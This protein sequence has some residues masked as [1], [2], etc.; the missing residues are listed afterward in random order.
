MKIIVDEKEWVHNH[1]WK[2]IL[3]AQTTRTYLS[4]MWFEEY[5]PDWTTWEN[6]DPNELYFFIWQ[7]EWRE[8]NSAGSIIPPKI[9]EKSLNRLRTYPNVIFLC[10]W[11]E[12]SYVQGV[13]YDELNEIISSLDIP[14]NRCHVVLS[15]LAYNQFESDNFIAHNI[16]YWTIHILH[17]AYSDSNAF[18]YQAHSE[19]RNKKALCLNR[20][21]REHRRY[22]LA[23][24]YANGYDTDTY[25]SNLSNHDTAIE[26]PRWAN[27]DQFL[28]DIFYNRCGPVHLD[29]TSEVAISNIIDINQDL[30]HDSY[31]HLVNETSFNNSVSNEQLYTKLLFITEKTL[32]PI[33]YKQLFIVVGNPG[34]LRHLHRLGVQTFPELFDE[35]Y[36][37]EHDPNKRMSTIQKNLDILFSM[38]YD[39]LHSWYVHYIPTLQ[40][41]FDRLMDPYF[42]RTYTKKQL[43]LMFDSIINRLDD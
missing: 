15:N 36:D 13:I 29:A 43:N 39:E 21:D 12:E 6:Y 1:K 4:P 20:R 9:S 3:P 8:E 31:V 32:K 11:P 26:Y 28:Q 27:K 16:D 23:Y 7:P 18:D 37:D 42:F 30:V 34:T 10:F 35:S 2:A 14:K 17:K 41:N 22:I 40:A 25:I 24:L 5:G 38:S 33:L 19:M